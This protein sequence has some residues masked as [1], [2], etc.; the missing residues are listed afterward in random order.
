MYLPAKI[1][2]Q[3]QAI[4]RVLCR[5]V[6]R[7]NNWGGGGVYSYIHV[8]IPE[9]QSLS[10]EIRRAEHDCQASRGPMQEF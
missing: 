1:S 8:H 6:A 3:Q 10:R 7:R 2:Y 9:K 4:E 5:A